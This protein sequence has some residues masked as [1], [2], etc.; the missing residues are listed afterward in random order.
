MQTFLFFFT[1]FLFSYS[2]FSQSPV[3]WQVSYQKN[4]K[5]ILFDAIIDKGWH[6]Y[7]VEVPS[8]KQGPLPTEFHFISNNNYSLVGNIQEK[9]PHLKYDKNFG[10]K[11]AFFKNKT[12]FVQQIETYRD[13]L[14]ISGFIKYMTCNE[15]A[16]YPYTLEFNNKINLPD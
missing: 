6:L 5:I 9:K 1:L 12:T 15:N 14:E 3:S 2:T 13:S 8:P 11:I 4:K 16:C 10:V 7:A